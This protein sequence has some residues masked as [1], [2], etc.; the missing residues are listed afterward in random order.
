M[1]CKSALFWQSKRDLSVFST[2]TEKGGFT[3]FSVFD[4][5]IWMGNGARFGLI[6]PQ[7][8]DHLI[9]GFFDGGI[10]ESPSHISISVMISPVLTRWPK[11][12]LQTIIYPR[13]RKIF[14]AIMRIFR[15]E[16]QTIQ[17]WELPKF[18]FFG[19]KTYKK[20]VKRCFNSSIKTERL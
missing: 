6:S 20:I 12:T 17:Y 10:R 1:R 4:R 8:P 7:G 14:F 2:R 18:V 11:P 16:K 19:K 5:I 13:Y 15:Y 9:S 3:G